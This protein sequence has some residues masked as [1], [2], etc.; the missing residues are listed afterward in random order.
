[1][2][3]EDDDIRPLKES[4]LS[5]LKPLETLEEQ[6]T[7]GFMPEHVRNLSE[8]NTTTLTLEEL[9]EKRLP[10][11]PN[12]PSSVL[13]EEMTM[14]TP[15]P[16]NDN[17]E[18]QSHFS[19][20]TINSTN[21]EQPRSHFSEFTV[22]SIG[23]PSSTYSSTFDYKSPSLSGHTDHSSFPTSPYHLPSMPETP[24]MNDGL[25]SYSL[26]TP[27]TLETKSSTREQTPSTHDDPMD[28]EDNMKGLCIDSPHPPSSSSSFRPP[29]LN[30]GFQG[31]K[32]PEDATSSALTL[33]KVDTSS[34]DTPQTDGDVQMSD[35]GW[36]D[37]AQSN[38]HT[39]T[40][41]QL[42]DELSYLG[43]MIQS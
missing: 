28:L 39:T 2:S 5:C 33:R 19:A 10:T 43:E 7:P 8:A 24:A 32:L 16:E 34:H 17:T 12:S 38:P 42:M 37:I 11:L 35:D 21:D 23:S 25:E 14:D 13:D 20:F 6:N 15:V 36:H 3:L 30:V 9:N 22:R 18:P 26:T 31:Y 29:G 4:V 41:Q 1:M 27:K 40:M